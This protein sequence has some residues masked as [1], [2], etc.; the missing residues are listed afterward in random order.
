MQMILVQVRHC[1]KGMR[2]QD[3]RSWDVNTTSGITTALQRMFPSAQVLVTNDSLVAAADCLA[4]ELRQ[5]R[6]VDLLV[7]LHGAGMTNMI[8]MKPNSVVLEITG[9]YDGRMVSIMFP[10]ITTTKQ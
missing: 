7:G 8:F 5:Y 9:Q 3:W 4:C 1:H 6:K 10:I 2:C